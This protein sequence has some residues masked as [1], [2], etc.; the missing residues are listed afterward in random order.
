MMATFSKQ[1]NS[2]TSIKLSMT[3]V[4]SASP[5]GWSFLLL[6]GNVPADSMS[7]LVN[8]RCPNW[9]AFAVRR[10]IF[11]F[12]R[13]WVIKRPECGSIRSTNTGRDRRDKKTTVATI[14]TKQQEMIPEV[15]VLTV[16][17]S[18]SCYGSRR[19]CYVPLV[20]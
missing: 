12:W 20:K 11:R 5:F 19:R 1:I 18:V 14:S 8:V 3:S 2:F 17:R 10:S 13:R 7:Q 15:Q 16:H 6:I 4:L 9:V